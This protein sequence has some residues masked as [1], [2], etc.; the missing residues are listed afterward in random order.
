MSDQTIQWLQAQSEGILL[1]MINQNRIN[2]SFMTDDAIWLVGSSMLYLRKE[3]AE[4]YLSRHFMDIPVNEPRFTYVNC[5]YLGQECISVIGSCTYHSMPIGSPGIK[6]SFQISW[7]KTDNTWKIKQMVTSSMREKDQAPDNYMDTRIDERMLLQTLPLGM[8]CCV[9]EERLPVKMVN[10]K[11][12]EMLGYASVAEYTHYMGDSLYQSIHPDDMPQFKEYVSS[13]GEENAPDSVGARL[14]CK[15]FTYRWYQFFGSKWDHWLVLTCTDNTDNQTY[16]DNIHRQRKQL[17]E[18]Q[19]SYRM[20]IDYLPSGF[21]RCRLSDPVKLD[22]VSDNFCA[23]TG[24]TR[25]DIREKIE[26]QYD[27][28]IV[29]EDRH[30]FTEAARI[31]MQYP[32]TDQ[33]VY[34]LQRKDGRIIRV[35]DKMRSVRHAD[36]S[37]WGYSIVLELD[38]HPVSH[39][40]AEKPAEKILRTTKDGHTVE[41]RTFGYFEVLVDGKPIAFRFGKARELL[42][43]LIDRKG[44]FISREGII[45]RLWEDEPINQTTQARCRKTFMNLV[46]ELRSYGIEDIVETENGQRRILPEK[47]NCDLFDYQNHDP[48]AMARFQGEYLNEYSWSEQTLSALLANN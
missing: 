29:P 13:I 2:T 34:R 19:D 22:Y 43:L 17:S 18:M 42:A 20:L 46:T 32:H 6:V 26:L 23:M 41:I 10:H 30:L 14:R 16:I 1:S 3:E 28:M 31:M 4:D 35:L 37:M 11:A 25:T 36:G 9:L 39:A 47:V 38:E 27:R 40:K 7:V 48:E 21:H 5:G 12:L 44:N 8:I 45:S 24:Y 33:F 15:D